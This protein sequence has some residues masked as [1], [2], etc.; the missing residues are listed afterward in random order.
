MNA[1]LP[2]ESLNF[3]GDIKRNSFLK[4]ITESCTLLL[5]EGD[6]SWFEDSSFS[7]SVVSDS[8]DPVR[9]GPPGPSVHGILQARTLACLSVY[10][11]SLA[12]RPP[13]II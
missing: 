12:K 7:R 11:V 10:V 4:R 1:L 5:L 6:F 13:S 3:V 9:C 8:R 2:W